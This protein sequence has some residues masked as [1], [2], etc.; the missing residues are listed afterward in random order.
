[1]SIDIATVGKFTD[2]FGNV[3]C[4]SMEL[5][6]KDNKPSISCVPAGTYDLQLYQSPRYGNSYHLV[7]EGLN[8]SITG[9]NTTRSH[10][11]IHPANCP[12][13]LQGCIAP[14]KSYGILDINHNGQ[15]ELAGLSSRKAYSELIEYIKENQITKLVIYRV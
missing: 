13:Q 10:I 11:L 6:W 14:C 5:P 8:V 2:R 1:M 7:N 9:E 4:K 12:S 3:I 15:Y